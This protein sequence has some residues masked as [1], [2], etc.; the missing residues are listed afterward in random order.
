MR[1]SKKILTIAAMIIL[2]LSVQAQNPITRRVKGDTTLKKS[3]ATIIK[4]KE[5]KRNNDQNNNSQ[6]TNQEAFNKLL[7]KAA[8]AASFDEKVSLLEKART[9]CYEHLKNDCKDLIDDRLEDVYAVE[10]NRLL[11]LARRSTRFSEKMDWLKKA[12]SL[13]ESSFAGGSARNRVKKAFQDE[14]DRFITRADNSNLD[15][16]RRMGHLRSALNFCEDYNN[17][18][19]ISNCSSKIE[20]HAQRLFDD[21]LD[22]KLYDQALKICRNLPGLSNC[23]NLVYQKEFDDLL[24]AATA[25]ANIED[26]QTLLE[27]ARDICTTHLQ[28]GCARTVNYRL[29]NIYADALEKV[30]EKA[31]STRDLREK[32][33]FYAEAEAFCKEAYAPGNCQERIDEERNQA[34][35]TRFDIL[36][37]DISRTKDYERQQELLKEAERLIAKGQ[38]PDERWEDIRRLKHQIHYRRLEF[39]LVQ[40][41][42][43]F[44][45][46]LRQL[47]QAEAINQNYLN[48]AYNQK[49]Q[50]RKVVLITNEINEVLRYNSRPFPERIQR[51][52][53]AEQL[54]QQ[55]NRRHR[56]QLLPKIRRERERIVLLE[57]DALVQSAR[58]ERRLDE[59]IE[60]YEEAL[61]FCNDFPDE[62]AARG[63]CEDLAQERHEVVSDVYRNMIKDAQKD[64]R[65]EFFEKAISTLSLAAEVYQKYG[66]DLI[67]EMPISAAYQQLYNQYLQSADQYTTRG[68]FGQAR[69]LLIE[70]QRLEKGK[71]WVVASNNPVQIQL[72]KINRMELDQKLDQMDRMIVNVRPTTDI[73]DLLQ[74]S[75]RLYAD[76]SLVFS[77]AQANRLQ[78]LYTSVIEN[79]IGTAMQNV[80]YQEFSEARMLLLQIK[81][82][83]DQ[84]NKLWTGNNVSSRIQQAFYQLYAE[85]M[86]TIDRLMQNNSELSVVNIELDN[87]YQHLTED[88]FVKS[89]QGTEQRALQLFHRLFNSYQSAI[90]SQLSR[91][92][93][94]TTTAERQLEAYYQAH[95]DI[96]NI[97]EFEKAQSGISFARHYQKAAWMQQKQQYRQAL[98]QWTE[99]LKLMEHAPAAYQRNGLA[100]ELQQ[101]RN[102][103]YTAE[104]NQQLRTLR[105]QTY[106]QNRIQSYR[107]LQ[108]FLN[109]YQLPLATYTIEEIK[110]LKEEIFGDICT[111]RSQQFYFKMESGDDAIRRNNYTAALR[112][113]EEA[114]SLAAEFPECGIDVRLAENKIEDYQSASIFQS[115]KI[116]LDQLQDR[117]YSSKQERDFKAY[118]EAYQSLSAFYQEKI[119]NKGFQL[120]L[121]PY[122]R[123]V[124]QIRNNDF[125]SYVVWTH[126]T[127]RAQ[128]NFTTE[129]L[130]ELI[131]DK[132]FSSAQLEKLAEKM[133]VQNYEVF[134]GK[135]YKDTFQYYESGSLKRNK[136]FKV[137]KKAYK[138]AYKRVS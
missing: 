14:Y 114:R 41:T 24:E 98:E 20:Y 36:L 56:Y 38:L 15:I 6:A 105:Q 91:N 4:G 11:T 76:N 23:Q 138:K 48:Q 82:L 27:K 79:S 89:I 42:G 62:I 90:L 58:N 63:G 94:N 113:Y 129:L 109:S 135:N 124:V 111:E 25:S 59:K 107:A 108:H 5:R 12:N 134:G 112:F 52:D 50:E 72:D 34:F 2:S 45:S 65:S 46:Q 64:M 29:R 100:N 28:N 106:Q 40:N 83:S 10:I 126:C 102:Q 77:T 39:L 123:K 122:Q 136:R 37:E 84:H 101:A 26:Q 127:D 133:A 99:A 132:R 1:S 117:I 120:N 75:C 55:L 86:N 33:R 97:K 96:F 32:L 13:S 119:M 44:E 85:R 35:N 87:M 128:L 57:Y 7:E 93:F 80:Q 104:V 31:R 51:L 67:R 60:L 110:S 9:I 116:E 95:T 17:I 92:D 73:L 74:E 30:L 88:Y 115:R 21:A 16:A 78:R 3:E 68:S 69:Q 118:Q 71:Y 53:Y 47:E 43:S 125:W 81:R 22:Q 137:L 66:N 103:A 49:I 8:E 18:L 130:S 19:D 121:V 131:R 61:L 70:A 54:T